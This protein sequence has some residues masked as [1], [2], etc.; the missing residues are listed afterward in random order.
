MNFELSVRARLDRA[1]GHFVEKAAFEPK[2]LTAMKRSEAEAVV[3]LSWLMYDDLAN[4]TPPIDFEFVR[5]P[6]DGHHEA[7]GERWQGRELTARDYLNDDWQEILCAAIE[8]V[9]A[10]EPAIETLLRISSAD[11]GPDARVERRS[12]RC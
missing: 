7:G 6:F 4:E 8:K 1:V 2:W 11:A 10:T 12:R 3:L 5:L 9:R